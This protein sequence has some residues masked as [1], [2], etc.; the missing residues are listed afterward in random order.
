MPGGGA[1]RDS[2]VVGKEGGGNLRP[3][4]PE[5]PALPGVVADRQGSQAFNH[6][7]LTGLLGPQPLLQTFRLHRCNLGQEE[8][9]ILWFLSG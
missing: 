5:V 4:C 8:C 7:G 1:L 9:T 3:A 6:L 2:K